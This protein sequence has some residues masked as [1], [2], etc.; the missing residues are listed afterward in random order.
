[1]I[2]KPPSRFWM[3]VLGLMWLMV[4]A[5]AAFLIQLWWKSADPHL[6]KIYS[7]SVYPVP[8]DHG[9][10]L[11]ITA[12][13][14]PAKDCLRFTQ[15]AL[16][17]DKSDAP[18]KIINRE[19]WAQREYVPLAAAVNGPAFGSVRDFTVT[20]YIPPSTEP[21]DWNYVARSVYWCTVFPG[22]TKSQESTNVPVVINLPED[23]RN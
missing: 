10:R 6:I 2:F 14:P 22:L 1:M 18:T 20:L 8:G 7:A 9:H 13:G 16:Y 3:I 12:E 21:G 15:H 5:G 11:V 19:I 4:G 23:V 17:R